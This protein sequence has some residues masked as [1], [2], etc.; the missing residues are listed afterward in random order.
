MRSKRPW[1]L[2][3]LISSQAQ[4]RGKA[5]THLA[6]LRAMA[7]SDDRPRRPCN[8]AARRGHTWPRRANIR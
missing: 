4:S 1:L 7:G 8:R 6:F 5:G 2:Y 3:L